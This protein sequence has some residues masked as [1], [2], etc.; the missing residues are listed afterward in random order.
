MIAVTA[1]ISSGLQ[2]RLKSFTGLARPC[3]L[4]LIHIVIRQFESKSKEEI[5]ASLQGE[6]GASAVQEAYEEV[7]EVAREGM[8]FTHA[9]TWL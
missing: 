3:R 2:P 9:G 4:S 7:E 6:F 5:I 1:T 8:L